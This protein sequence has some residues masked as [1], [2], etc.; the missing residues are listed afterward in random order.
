[1]KQI[2]ENIINDRENGSVMG[3]KDVCIT[4][5]QWWPEDN[6]MSTNFPNSIKGLPFT[7]LHLP[8]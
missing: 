5:K 7:E 1:M 6:Q 8:C 4:S 2:C 3:T